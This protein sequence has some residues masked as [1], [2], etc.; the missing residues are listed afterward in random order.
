MGDDEMAIMMMCGVASFAAWGTTRT[1]AL[2]ALYTRDNPW[3]GAVKLAVL[4]GLA[5]VYFVIETYGDPSIVG[6][7][8]FFYLLMAYA[9]IKYAGQLAAAMHGPRL[10]VDVFERKN[11]AAAIVIVAMTLAT[12]AIFSGS[13]WGE[14]DPYGD[15]EGGWWIPL[16]FFAAGWASLQLA[17]FLFFAREKG[18][19]RSRLRGDRDARLALAAASYILGVAAML[20]E[21]VAGDFFGWSHGLMAVAGV[22][23]MLL[24]HELF[25]VLATHAGKRLRVLEALVYLATAFIVPPVGRWVESLAAV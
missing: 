16:G 18:R 10:R 7:Y 21:A 8:V 15:D 14:A 11:P 25:A 12:A 5:W 24:L 6:I 19:T 3:I 9:I 2:H 20:T 4:L 13:L 22:V 17:V 1:G 23:V